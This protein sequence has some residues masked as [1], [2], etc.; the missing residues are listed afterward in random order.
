MSGL[1][2]LHPGLQQ[3]IKE[4]N[5]NGLRP[6]QHAALDP[7]LAGESCVIEAPTAGG[8]TEAVLFPSL[9]RA[10]QAPGRSVQILYIAPLRALL[11]NLETRGERY[12][13][14][15]GL[16]AFKWHG[17]VSQSSKVASLTNPPH[18]L[19]RR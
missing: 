5:W 19:N 16:H 6:I 11:N 15:C 3:W 14:C 12:A 2:R 18:L 13:Q 4:Q 17:D 8:K 10:A 7:I 9:T 1:E